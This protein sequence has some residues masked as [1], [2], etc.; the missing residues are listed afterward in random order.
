MF[1]DRLTMSARVFSSLTVRPP[2]CLLDY[3]PKPIFCNMFDW[4]AFGLDAGSL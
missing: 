1:E 3:F 4:I 2:V